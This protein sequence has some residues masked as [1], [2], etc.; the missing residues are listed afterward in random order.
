MSPTEFPI[1]LFR[2]GRIR[3]TPNALKTL[4]EPDIHTG[5]QRHQAGDWGDVDNDDRDANDQALL[6]GTRLFSVYHSANRVKFWIITEANRSSTIILL[7][8]DY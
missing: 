7:P 5:L 6:E 1:A 3:A 8:E 2:V 4:S